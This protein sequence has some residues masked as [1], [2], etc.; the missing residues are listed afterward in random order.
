MRDCIGIPSL[1]QHTD[2]YDIA[3]LLAWLSYASDSIDFIAQCL[4]RFLL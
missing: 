4:S 3:D 1:R 2:G